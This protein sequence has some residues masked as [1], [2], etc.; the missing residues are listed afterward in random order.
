MRKRKKTKIVATLGPAVAT[1]AKIKELMDAG[2]YGLKRSDIE[3]K[4]ETRRRPGLEDTL[5]IIAGGVFL[6]SSLYLALGYGNLSGNVIGYEEGTSISK[7]LIPAISLGTL[8]L[9]KR[10]I[11]KN[12]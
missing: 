2:V 4:K 11:L 7:F 3:G 6:I 8:L 9:I 1:K 10:K 12:F 5:G